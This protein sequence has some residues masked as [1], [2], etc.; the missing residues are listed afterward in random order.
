MLPC[1]V[2]PSERHHV[3]DTDEVFLRE[4]VALWL[5]TA[6]RW[7]LDAAAG[8]CPIP[9]KLDKILEE[10]RMADV[11]YGKDLETPVRLG[12]E[13]EIVIARGGLRHKDVS[14]FVTRRKV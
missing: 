5:K 3:R 13:F 12:P 11:A 2:R 4:D 7:A 6:Y 9:E 10:V 8:Q 14:D 1:A